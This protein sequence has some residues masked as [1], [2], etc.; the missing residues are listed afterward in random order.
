MSNSRKILKNLF[1]L[2]LAT[3]VSKGLA[4]IYTIY[5]M[6]TIGPES[7][8]I[9]NF[10]KS[11][12]QYF[13]LLIILGFDQLGIREVAKDKSLMKNY[14]DLITTIR[15]TLSIFSY[16]LLFILV[17]ILIV[18]KP[19]ISNYQHIIFIYSLIILSN[20]I[21]LSWIFQAVEKMEIIAIR[22]IGLYIVNFVGILVFVKKSDDLIIAVSIIAFSEILNSIIMYF[23]YKKQYFRFNFNF[24]LV[25]WKVIFRDSL[26]IGFIFMIATLYNNID[27]TLL[28]M[29]RGE[30]ETGIY[31]AGHQVIIFGIL[32]SA[33]IQGAFFPQI[34]QRNTFEERDRILSKYAKLQAFFAYYVAGN[35]FFLSDFA[36]Y[37]LGEKYAQTNLILQYLS[38]TVLIQFIITIYFSP[39]ISWKQERKVIYANIVGLIIN[40]GL[41]IALIPKYGMYGSAVATIFCE[42]G[43]LVVMIRVFKTIHNKLYFKEIF[44]FI[45]I[46]FIAFLPIYLLKSEIHPIVGIVISSIIF[47]GTTFA[48]KIITIN[49]I[50]SL[51]K[52]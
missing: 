30:F 31:G 12:V 35:L 15:L 49:E 18:G 29:F 45:P 17:Q 25:E 24:N 33:I 22:T 39:L 43:V 47:I 16:L 13:V 44:E 6:R 42:F 32:P 38:F 2:S 4:F 41:N 14:V 7:N 51:L 8:G 28:G 10:S 5:L 48:F 21:N 23:I 20:A 26:S 11:L 40:V 34:I 27:I 1:S 50:K 37:L 3:F 9:L 46:T 52:K 19:E 36:V